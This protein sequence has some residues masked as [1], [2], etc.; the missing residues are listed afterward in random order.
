MPFLVEQNAWLHQLVLA[1]IPG[2]SFTHDTTNYNQP[3]AYINI[4]RCHQP[5]S[6]V[7]HEL[8]NYCIKHVG[9]LHFFVD[10]MHAFLVKSCFSWRNPSFPT[11]SQISVGSNSTIYPDRNLSTTNLAGVVE[12]IDRS[13]MPASS[14]GRVSA[15]GHAFVRQGAPRGGTRWGPTQFKLV[16]KHHEY[17]L[18]I[19]LTPSSS[20]YLRQL[21][22][23][24]PHPVLGASPQNW[25]NTEISSP[26]CNGITHDS[27]TF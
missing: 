19:L 11:I 22:M 26:I 23:W 10:E 27:G 4:L 16:Y 5:E 17:P 8:V 12:K 25:W 15:Q 7:S 21:S 24:G 6:E 3:T 18:T 2:F 9:L 1:C 14:I 13:R 20:S